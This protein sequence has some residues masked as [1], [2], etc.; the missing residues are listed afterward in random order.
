MQNEFL[1]LIAVFAFSSTQITTRFFQLK[2]Q[3]SRHSINLYQALYTLVAALAYFCVSFVQGISFS[4]NVILPSLLFGICF[5]FATLGF[6]KCMDMG[7]MSLSAV[8]I[9]LSL[10]LPVMFS[11][12]FMGERVTLK[13]VIGLVLIIITLI[14]S[15][16]STDRGFKEKNKKWLFYIIIAFLANGSSAI[17]QKQYKAAFGEE[18]LMMFMSLAY[19][20][21][22]I[23]FLATYIFKD[24]KSDVKIKEQV[25]NPVMLL[26]LAFISGLGSFGGNGLLGVLCDKVNGG[27]LYPCIN[28]GLSIVSALSSF[29]IF[30]ET[31]TSKKIIALCSGISAIILLN[32]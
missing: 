13:A 11:W 8:I 12:T 32:I 26:L 14:L 19:L 7:Y 25:K 31:L 22:S 17:V 5:A 3:K 20:T 18:D 15:S 24:L 28:G 23:I 21:A 2:Q 29:L 16:L 30:K 9:N 1:I 10:I 4:S 6:A 27:I